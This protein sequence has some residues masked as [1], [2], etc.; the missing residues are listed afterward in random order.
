MKDIKI[1]F[2]VNIQKNK[3]FSILFII[4]I[5]NYLTCCVYKEIINEDIFEVFIEY[6]LLLI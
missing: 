3:N 5:N 2:K 6:E 4:N 1:S